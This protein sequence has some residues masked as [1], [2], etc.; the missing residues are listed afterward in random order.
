MYID[1]YM[2]TYIYIYIYIHTIHVHIYIYTIRHATEECTGMHFNTIQHATEQYVCTYIYIYTYVYIYMKRMYIYVYMHN[3]TCNSRTQKHAIRI[4]RLA[5]SKPSPPTHTHTLRV[6]AR[7]IVLNCL[8][9]RPTGFRF[10]GLGVATISRLLKI[11]RIA[12]F[13][14][15][16]LHVV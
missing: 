10:E 7:S 14:V 15:P 8:L 12:F 6:V 11:L 5:P 3:T 2:Y 4:H 1:K 16:L 9:L 13:C